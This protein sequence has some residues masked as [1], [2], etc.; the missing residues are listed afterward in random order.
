MIID[1]AQPHIANVERQELVAA[2][3]NVLEWPPRSPDLNPIE[4]LSDN[5]DRKIRA[6][7]NLPLTLH[8][9]SISL[10]EI[11]QKEVAALIKVC[12]QELQLVYEQQLGTLV[13]NTEFNQYLLF[14]FFS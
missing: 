10:Q 12:L 14:T 7:E 13:I 8:K 1:N 2:N 6:H 5:F 4:H 3:I 9:L 11:H